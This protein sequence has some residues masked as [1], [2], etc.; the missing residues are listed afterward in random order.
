MALAGKGRRRASLVCHPDVQNV[1][2]PR[3]QSVIGGLPLLKDGD[4]FMEAL[5]YKFCAGE[6]KCI[7]E[8]LALVSPLAE[9]SRTSLNW[10]ARPRSVLPV[11]PRTENGDVFAVEEIQS[12][13]KPKNVYRFW[14]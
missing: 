8:V 3:Q 14:G 5:E 2:V 7:T 12:G 10:K 13:T 1:I 4:E 9:Y 11:D 6:H